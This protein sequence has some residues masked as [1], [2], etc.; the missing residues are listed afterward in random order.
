M[1]IVLPIVCTIE[2]AVFIVLAVFAHFRYPHVGI[3]KRHRV[4]NKK[5]EVGHFERSFR[6][7]ATV[8][9]R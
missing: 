1:K 8:R 6:P 3:E 7:Q 4:R 2:I 5:T 9:F